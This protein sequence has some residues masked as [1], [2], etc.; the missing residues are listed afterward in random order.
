M[1]YHV[2]ILRTGP[3]EKTIREDEI[4]S[5]V[6]KQ[7]GFEI[8]QNDAG[9]IEQAFREISGE[10]VLLFY[11][12]TE[13]WAKTPGET[14]LRTMIEIARAL[15]NGARVRVTRGKP[16]RALRRPFITRTMPRYWKKLQSSTGKTRCRWPYQF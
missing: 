5:V 14:T 4:V 12:G 15:G 9:S 8:E 6:G 13:L 3:R 11:D 7:F 10:E 16:T 2:A 1:G